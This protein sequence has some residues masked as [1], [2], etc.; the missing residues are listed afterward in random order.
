MAGSKFG[1]RGKLPPGQEGENVQE[2]AF[3]ETGVLGEG[4][5]LRTL[6]GGLEADR[7][8]SEW[9]SAGP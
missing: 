6:E 4:V 3:E 9:R 2:G 5:Q 7:L 1:Q 8:E